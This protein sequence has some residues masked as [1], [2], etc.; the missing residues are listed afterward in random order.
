[1]KARS[2][3]GL[4]IRSL[5]F[6]ICILATHRFAI[7]QTVACASIATPDPVLWNDGYGDDIN[8]AQTSDGNV[9]GDQTG[10][11]IN[12]CSYNFSVLDG[13]SNG[14]GKFTLQFR[15]DE[16]NQ[17]CAADTLIYTLTV[18]GPGCARATGTV[19]GSL[20]GNQVFTNNPVTWSD[21][22]G[23]QATDDTEFFLGWGTVQEAGLAI[24]G[25]DINPTT[26]N[27]SGRQITE[28]FP[29][30]G[31][32]GCWFPG[33]K[34]PEWSPT[35]ATAYVTLDPNNN[36]GII[37]GYGDHVG[38]TSTTTL[39]YYRQRGQAPCSMTTQQDISIDTYT[40]SEQYQEN[41]MVLTIGTNT[42]TIQRGSLVEPRSLPSV[43]A[44]ALP[45]AV[46]TLLSSTQF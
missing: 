15:W 9:S 41:S 13:S 25:I 21:G 35:G 23:V 20:G 40:A 29:S 26:Y 32:D 17:V 19:S 10:D 38:F 42:V 28:S 45:G 5:A 46:L 8:L 4:L 24:F 34:I 43:Y 16:N 3:L 2:R 36:N 22:D 33:S 27:F 12:D 18:S 44:A 6:G 31:A 39:D 1:M 7:A 14:D 37:S 11:Y 30:G